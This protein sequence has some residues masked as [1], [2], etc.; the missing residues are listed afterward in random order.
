MRGYVVEVSS[1]ILAGFRLQVRNIFQYNNA[2]KKAGQV[3]GVCQV[4]WKSDMQV[5][6]AAGAWKISK[7]TR[8]G[9]REQSHF[10][11]SDNGAISQTWREVDRGE[12]DRREL[13]FSPIGNDIADFSAFAGLLRGPDATSHFHLSLEISL[14][15]TFDHAID[16]GSVRADA[17]IIPIDSDDDDLEV[18]PYL[19]SATNPSM[20]RLLMARSVLNSHF[21]R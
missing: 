21:D 10:E 12:I 11:V 14:T 7:L 13:L 1:G 15:E 4:G 20:Y 6:I 16:M 9:S 5:T 2:L 3:L 17:E 18:T 19:S 8:L